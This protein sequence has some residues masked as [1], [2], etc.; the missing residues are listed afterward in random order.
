[1]SSWDLVAKKIKYLRQKKK[2]KLHRLFVLY[3]K[4]HTNI[5]I[6]KIVY[7]DKLDEKKLL[8]KWVKWIQFC[9]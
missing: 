4:N 1:M 8:G 6:S 5:L 3:Y 7:F 2:L 9:S